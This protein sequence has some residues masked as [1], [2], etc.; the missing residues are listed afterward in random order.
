MTTTA[1]LFYILLIITYFTSTVSARTDKYR[2]MWREDP[3]TT[4]V[5]GWNQTSGHSP[6]VYYDLYDGGQ[7]S[8]NYGYFQKP[9]RAIQAKGMDNYFV[10]LKGLIPNTR[11]YF[12]IVDSEGVSKRMSFQTVPSDSYDRLS[13]IAGGDSRNF[14]AGRQNAN[15]LVAKLQPHFVLFGGDMTG[16][17]TGKEWK[18]WFDDWQLT[19]TPD[20]K[21]TPIVATRGNHE[22]SNAT[23]SNLFDVKNESIYYALNF[24]GDLLRVYTLNSLIA[25]GGD[26]KNWLHYDLGNH[27]HV[28]WKMAQYHFAT[29]PHTS[30]KAERN[31]QLVN[32]SSLFYEYGVNLVV[33]SDAHCVKTTYPIRPSRALKADEGFVRDDENGTV[34]VGEGCWGAPLRKNNDD[35]KWTR[36]SGS[37]NQFK[38]IF[39][40]QN[41]IQVRTVKTDRADHAASLSEYDRFSIPAGLDIW[42]PSNGD[43]IYIYPRNSSPVT[44]MSDG[45][46]SHSNTNLY[47]KTAA[48]MSMGSGATGETYNQHNPIRVPIAPVEVANFDAKVDQS[49]VS[50]SWKTKNDF[51]R[52]TSYEIQR[53]VDNKAFQTIAKVNGEGSGE[54]SYK[55]YDRGYG[56]SGES[57]LK[58][59]I[60]VKNHMGYVN[61]SDAKEIN[62]GLMKWN[63]YT[64]L[65][66]DEDGRV[67]VKYKLSEEANVYINLIDISQKE[68]KSTKYSNQRSGNYRN[69][70]DISRI[71]SGQYLLTIKTDQRVIGQFR[72]VKDG[73]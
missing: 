59:R 22:Y 16:G 51:D 68:I 20:G 11:Y 42:N 41:E 57:V 29:R 73:V 17:D 58:Y 25:S 12:I 7:S 61:I 67:Q 35:K 63:S 28:K 32:W 47:K 55:I 43:V 15:K 19:I 62:K 31:D 9:D 21:L 50:I 3:S 2:C 33:E 5:I 34:Y 66:P 14:R 60:S 13:V 54:S 70:I 69:S 39:I 72:I 6:V 40:D 10:R 26:Q 27:S 30:R 37:F 1:R 8:N 38:W 23:I 56:I 53:S 45:Q 36:N 71:P 49:D 24:G 4:M 48:K 65:S 52:N 64:A 46:S 44:V 18:E